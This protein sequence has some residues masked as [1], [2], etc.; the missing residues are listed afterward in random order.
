M[1]T[2]FRSGVS[3]LIL[4]FVIALLAYRFSLMDF[5]KLSITQILTLYPGTSVAIIIV[6]IIL[7]GNRYIIKDDKLV[8]RIASIKMHTVKLSDIISI[9]RTYNPLS[10]PASSLKRLYITITNSRY[11]LRISPK[12][13]EGFLKLIIDKNPAIKI[14]VKREKS[15]LRFWDWDI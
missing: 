8:V 11:G 12:D 13:E 15:I 4:T 3:I 7:F 10:S 14:N 5:D 2:V 1:K 9:E 6:L